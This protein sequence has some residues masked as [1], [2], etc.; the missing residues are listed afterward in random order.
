MKCG[1][2]LERFD[3][4]NK[5]PIILECNHILCKQCLREISLKFAVCP[6]GREK[7]TKPLHTLD[8]N[9]RLLEEISRVESILGPQAQSNPSS[10]SNLIRHSFR[11]NVKCLLNHPLK[12]L[13]ENSV[14]FIQKN[15][16]KKCTFCNMLANE[17]SWVCKQCNFY[18]CNACFDQERVA[19]AREVPAFAKCSQRHQLYLYTSA[20]DFYTRTDGNDGSILCEIC[21]KKWHG[22]SW[23]CRGCK[24]DICIQCKQVMGDLYYDTYSPTQL[25]QLFSG[26]S[27]D[28]QQALQKAYAYGIESTETRR[29]IED[30]RPSSEVEKN[31]SSACRESADI[32]NDS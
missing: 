13:S 5:L 6:F 2:C 12:Y 1:V 8:V 3:K 7:I 30:V 25:V 11:S 32:R 19:Q 27:V 17:G 15:E 20:T 14:I 4:F 24:Y 26:F 28:Y 31:S 29:P 23:S 9:I 21:R 22:E 16:S 10:E 18:I